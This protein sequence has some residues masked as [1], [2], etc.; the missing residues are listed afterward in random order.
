MQYIPNVVVKMK[1]TPRQ[2]VLMMRYRLLDLP[3]TVKKLTGIVAS[4]TQK[5]LF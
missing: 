1:E 2:I 4:T 3:G 5:K